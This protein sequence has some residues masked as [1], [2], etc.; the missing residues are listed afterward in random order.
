MKT[1]LRLS[2]VALLSLGCVGCDQATKGVARLYLAPGVTQSFF[3]DTLRLS[4][5]EN[6][7]AFL[8]L[9]ESLPPA[10]RSFILVAAVG[11]LLV[12]MLGAA[13]LSRRMKPLHIVALSLL[14]GG[15]I[16]NW[17]DRVLNHGRVTDFLNLGL[18]GLRTGIFNVADVAILAGTV[19]LAAGWQRSR[20]G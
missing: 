16:S 3:H 5:T 13:L 8:S 2:I 10:L 11:L 20:S 4:Y 15:G 9:G 19:L 7:G 6:T 17:L 12:M 1:S 14:A 18:G